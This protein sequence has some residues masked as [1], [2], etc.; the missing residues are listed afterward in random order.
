MISVR[1][2]AKDQ[3]TIQRKY[4]LQRFFPQNSAC[5]ETTSHSKVLRVGRTTPDQ[6][7]KKVQQ[8]DQCFIT[9]TKPEPSL[10]IYGKVASSVRG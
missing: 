4:K 1:G 10:F 5:T 3:N 8:L 6:N 7:S 2:R 9:A